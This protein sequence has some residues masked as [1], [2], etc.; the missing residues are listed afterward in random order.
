[1]SGPLVSRVLDSCLPSWLK[2]YTAALASFAADDGT[3]VFPSVRTIARMTGRSERQAARAFRELRAFGV[4]ERIGRA[5]RYASVEYRIN[6]GALPQLG[7]PDQLALFPQGARA[8]APRGKGGVFHSFNRRAHDTGVR[9]DLTPMS[10][11][12]SGDP[13]ITTHQFARARKGN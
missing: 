4:I 5:H 7:D 6:A 3:S 1:M 11:D 10:G 12:P 9:S 2:L 8:S 13:S